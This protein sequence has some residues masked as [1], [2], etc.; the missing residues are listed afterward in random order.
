[1]KLYKA[2]ERFYLGKFYLVVPASIIILSCI[3]SLAV[4]Y[5]TKKGMSVVNFTQMLLCVL[6]SMAYLTTVLGQ[7]PRKTTFQF[8]V[9]GLVLEVVMLVLNLLF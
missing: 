8:F 7:S 4:Y 9:F 3:G 1:M 5:I 2:I 6:G